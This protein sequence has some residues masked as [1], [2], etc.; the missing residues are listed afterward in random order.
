MLQE[1]NDQCIC[2][3]RMHVC[4]PQTSMMCGSSFLVIACGLVAG[5]V[6][7]M[8][9]RSCVQTLV[10]SKLR[11][12]RLSLNLNDIRK[13]GTFVMF[14]CMLFLMSRVHF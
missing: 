10:G 9:Q 11:L 5:N 2:Y 8:I 12:I 3:H 7:L 13:I 14:R 6:L 1:K 4:P